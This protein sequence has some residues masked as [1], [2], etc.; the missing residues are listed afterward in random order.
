[1]WASVTRLGV[2]E[3]DPP[4]HL[5]TLATEGFGGDG[6]ENV[7]N[8]AV[9]QPL[10]VALLGRLGLEERREA[11]AKQTSDSYASNE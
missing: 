11:A 8:V 4:I 5:P 1:M 7:R 9:N 2:R 3:G 10:L 6:A